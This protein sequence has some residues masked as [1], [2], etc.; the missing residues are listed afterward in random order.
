MDGAAL[1]AQYAAADV[2]VLP[3]F[4]EGYGMAVAEA[5]ARGL[6]VISTPTGAIAELVN[7][8]GPGQPQGPSPKPPTGRGHISPDQPAGLL[9]PPGDASALAAALSR[10]IG[11][12]GFRLRLAAGAR[13]MREQ[14]PTWKDAARKM[15]AVLGAA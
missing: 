6:P 9:V 14:L 15:A 3:T 12:R 8:C 1:D 11:D 4:Y 7:G 10:V 5:L 13:R 2:F